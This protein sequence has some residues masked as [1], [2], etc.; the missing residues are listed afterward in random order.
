MT[1]ITPANSEKDSVTSNRTLTLPRGLCFKPI[2]PNFWNLPSIYLEFSF[3]PASLWPY[4]LIPVIAPDLWVK[5]EELL[6]PIFPGLLIGK[7]SFKSIG[8][9]LFG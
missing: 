7:E 5:E 6:L 4:P 3:S 9:L 2:L 8:E 1:H